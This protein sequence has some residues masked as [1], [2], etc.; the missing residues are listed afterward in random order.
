MLISLITLFG[1][2]ALAWAAINMM[3]GRRVSIGAAYRQMFSRWQS[4]AGLWFLTI[5]GTI[6]LSIWTVLACVVGWFTGIGM[7]IFFTYIITPL[8]L[9]IIM[10]ENESVWQALPRAWQL[11]RQ[12][13]WWVLF[14]V[15]FLTLLTQALILGPQALLGSGIGFVLLDGV[16]GFGTLSW[17]A[18]AIT[19]GSLLLA[20][21]ILPIYWSG[22]VALYL[23]LRVRYEGVDL[24]LQMRV[25]ED[26][27]VS[28]ENPLATIP[29]APPQPAMPTG[30]EW[31][32]FVA[33]TVGPVLLILGFY[34][35]LIGLV[36]A[37]VAVGGGF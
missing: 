8:A 20:M 6:A 3:L 1:N 4:I 18:I 27:L 10:A 33:L 21:V 29:K 35:I 5:V 11:T 37:I 2:G 15:L 30:S 34:G 16:S 24:A 9:V 28:A 36:F 22:L 17:L 31:G 32:R 23:D 12:R 19:V 14:L 13:F 26:D 7:L 25:V